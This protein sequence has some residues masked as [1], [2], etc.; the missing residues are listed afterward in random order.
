M[1]GELYLTGRQIYFILLQEVNMEGNQDKVMEARLKK[2][3]CRA[4]KQLLKS[5]ES[6]PK[7]LVIESD[8]TKIE[9]SE[10]TAAEVRAF[11]FRRR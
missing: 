8:G 4:L 9:G 7:T 6:E 2:A 11:L 5:I 3:V 1:V 10:Q